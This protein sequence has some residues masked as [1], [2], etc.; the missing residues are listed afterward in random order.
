MAV[1]VASPAEKEKMYG[2][3]D[4]TGSVAGALSASRRRGVTLIEAVLYIAVSLALIVGGLV[5]Y[6]QASTASRMNTLTTML[7]SIMAETR[8]FGQESTSAVQ[9]VNY[10]A[11]LIARGSITEAW[12]DRTR[13]VWQ[14]IRHPWGGYILFEF[15]F[16]ATTPGGYEVVVTLNNLPLQVCS[17]LAAV[18]DTGRTIYSG[19]FSSAGIGDAHPNVVGLVSAPISLDT[20]AA[21]CRT[22]DTNNDGRTNVEQF[23]EFS[24]N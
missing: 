24:S 20:A 22:G 12:M 9:V 6:Q 15:Y 23:F 17:R 1:T 10:S 19:G 3:R 7:T 5:F 11:L 16:S 13:P 2:M 21:A 14:Q 18:S 4:M 8:A